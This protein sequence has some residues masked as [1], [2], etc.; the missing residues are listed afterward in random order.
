MGTLFLTSLLQ[1][2]ETFRAPTTRNFD[3]N[4][5]GPLRQPG[6]LLFGLWHRGLESVDRSA[7]VSSEEVSGDVARSPS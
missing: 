7:L 2:I 4:R 6:F 1:D 3:E 5:A